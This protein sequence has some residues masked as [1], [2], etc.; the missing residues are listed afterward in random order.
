[1]S[2]KQRLP[3]LR[4]SYGGWRGECRLLKTGQIG[5]GREAAAADCGAAPGKGDLD[6]AA[7]VDTFAY[8]KSMLINVGDEKGALLD[9]AVRRANQQL[10]LE[11]GTYCGTAR[12]ASPARPRRPRCTPSNSPPPTPRWRGASGTRASVTA[13]R[14][15]SARSATA[16]DPGRAGHRARP[17]PARSICCSS[18]TTRGPTFPTCGASST[19]AGCIPAPSPWPI[20]S[21]SPERRSTAYMREQQGK[22]WNTVEHKT[23]VEYQTLL[24]DLVLESEYLGG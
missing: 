10:A 9:A 2:L 22:L 12:C 7:T 23:H 21:V 17:R 19:A 13:S 14:A 18:T 3:F 11:L 24:T 15:W 6:N 20:T 16:G 5:D 8:E 1:M 4:S